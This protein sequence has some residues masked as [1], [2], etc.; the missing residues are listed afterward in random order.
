M[1]TLVTHRNLDVWKVSMDFVIDLYRI[2]D[3]F[4]SSEKFGLASQ[5]RRAGV[6]VCSNI[7]EGAA[8]HYSKEFI[9][10]LYIA[11]GS[12]VEIETQLE[13]AFNLGYLRSIEAEKGT[14]DRLRKMLVRLIQAI[15][16]KI[17]TRDKN[18][19]A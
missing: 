8:R 6:S 7:A 1:K 18:R 14:L 3:G 12:V 19:D 11:L 16:K 4:P 2:T 10:F 9:Q 5:I 13:I 15:E 17:V